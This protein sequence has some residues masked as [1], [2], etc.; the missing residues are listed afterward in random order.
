MS[1]IS[2]SNNSLSGP[3]SSKGYILF[4][5]F[6][7]LLVIVGFAYYGQPFY[8][9]FMTGE[10]G[11]SRAFVTSGNAVGK[12]LVG[13][14]FGFIA[15]MLVDRYGPRL[16]MISGV[17]FASIAFVGL[18]QTS[19]RE[20]FYLFCIFNALGYVCA[21]PLPCQVLVSRW[22]DKNRGKAMG[23][24]YL[25][26]GAGGAIVPMIASAMERHWGWHTSMLAV[27]V[28]VFVIAMP[29]VFFIKGSKQV[30]EASQKE[31]A[32][33]IREILKDR[34]FYLLALASMSTI[35]A[36]GGISQHLKLYLKDIDFSQADAA[37]VF[38]TMLFASLAGRVLIGF[39][40][41]W[42]NRKYVMLLIAVIIAASIPLLMVPPF[43]AREFIFAIT[44][45]IGLGGTYMIV[46]LV[47]ADLFG[48]RALG[49]V[50]GIILVA[51][52]LAEA[53]FPMLV[54][55]LYNEST[56]GYQSGFAILTALALVGV[57]IVIILPKLKNYT[58]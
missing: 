6:L 29:F 30:S 22:F 7:S 31:P 19:S 24:A 14:L 48:V 52:G 41:D 27:G 16:M 55:L 8:Y 28:L 53:I 26:I 21:G 50:M 46:P 57:V 12:L 4:T 43:V 47:A 1:I 32:M 18:S 25:G 11:W 44:F 40:S 54:G 9:D 37:A 23:I 42:I 2:V 35:G 51:D 5:A 39:L 10:Y 3:R 58:R 17:L 33:P 20:M 34:N 56:G 49:R 45:G 15:G 38:S 13:P 36:V